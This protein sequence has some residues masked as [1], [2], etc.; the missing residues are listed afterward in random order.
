MKFK[1]DINKL[2]HLLCRIIHCFQK[3]RGG[4]CLYLSAPAQQS[5]KQIKVF[6]N[7]TNTQLD[8][9]KQYLAQS[10]TDLN[11]LQLGGFNKLEQILVGFQVKT[12]FR[13]N[14]IKCHIDIRQVIP[15]Y[16]HEVIIH[17]I[18]VLIELALF[19]EGNNPAEISAFS[20]FINWKE[21]IGRERALGVMGFALGEFDSELFTRDFKILLDEQEFNKRSF[22][23]LA[24]HQQQNIFNQSFTAQKDLDIFYQQMEAEEKPKLDAN[25]WFDIVSTKIE[26]MHVIEKELIDLMCHKHSVNFEKIEN[27]LFSSSEKQQILEF[28]LF[29]NLTDKVKDGLFMSSNVRNYKKGSLLFLEGEPASRIYVVISGWVKIFKSSA[30]GQENIEHML[31]SGDMVIESSIFSSSNYNNNAQVSTESKLLSFPSAIYRNWVGK[32]L[33]LALNSLK[34]LSQS[35]KK[36]QQQID[37]NRVKSST[38]RV[39]QFLL[40]EFIKQ[41][42]P[43][44]ILLPYE[45]TIIASVLNMKPETFSRSLKALKKNGLSSE[46]QQIQIKDIKML[47][48]Y[49]D[50]E[51]SESCQFKNNYECKHQKTINQLQ[52]N[53]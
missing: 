31:T 5:S 8:L 44:T 1:S 28:P 45:K 33:T 15:L 18:Y 24:S 14:L 46:K 6:I 26:M 29:R 12:P 52:A 47:C 40:K 38:E 30:D 13:N 50:K 10:D 49:C 51:I 2:L 53:P 21:R 7:E 35:S 25:F 39:G 42:N 20:N 23:A 34:Y 27:R 4:L 17:L 19:D 22:L 9:L 41:K 36:Y 37:I 16:T 11:E 43:N 32:D 48:S 3:E